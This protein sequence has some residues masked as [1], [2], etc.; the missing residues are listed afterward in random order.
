MQTDVFAMPSL[1]LHHVASSQAE[2]QEERW[3]RWKGHM[4]G[5]ELRLI[6]KPAMKEQIGGKAANVRFTQSLAR[7]SNRLCPIAGPI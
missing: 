5:E 4:C 7:P 3:R 1:L 2:A 6:Q